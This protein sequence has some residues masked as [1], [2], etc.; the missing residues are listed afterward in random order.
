MAYQE[1][2]TTNGLYLVDYDLVN[3][4]IYDST[5][6]QAK[7]NNAVRKKEKEG[8]GLPETYHW[9]VDYNTAKSAAAAAPHLYGFINKIKMASQNAASQTSTIPPGSDI[10]RMK[11]DLYQY[12]KSGRDAGEALKKK[13]RDASSKSMA[14]IHGKVSKWET[15]LEVAKFTRDASAE[16]IL[17]SSVVV[18][19]G[20]TSLAIGAGGSL[21]KG[22]AKW[23]DTGNLGLGVLQASVSFVTVLIPGPKTGMDKGLARMLIFT[24]AKSEFTGNVVVG[25][26]EGKSIGESS[27]SAGVDLALGKVF[28]T[29]SGKL[30]PEK[31][32]G[33]LLKAGLDKI[34]IPVGLGVM[35]TSLSKLQ[36]KTNDAITKQLMTLA[37][38]TGKQPGARGLGHVA[39]AA[40]VL[41]DYAIIGPDRSTE[42]R[43]W[44]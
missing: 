28:K 10:E 1:V 32:M 26:A 31:E 11:D 36:G 15:A 14:N 44:S 21:L 33:L 6:L 34:A 20:A 7:N 37:K 42:A 35:N 41:V 12:E 17:V 24:K 43:N 29:I 40:P 16:I 23:Q 39:I 8:W 2:I 5:Y 19:G 38:R 25:L 30:I 18:S 13:Q 3:R 9:E 27:V 4:I 22:A